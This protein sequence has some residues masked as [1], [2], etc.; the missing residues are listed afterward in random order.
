MISAIFDEIALKVN[1]IMAAKPGQAAPDVIAYLESKTEECA[2]T[3]RDSLAKS[4]FRPDTKQA[5]ENFINSTMAETDAVVK[6][7]NS[8]DAFNKN[9]T[10]TANDVARQVTHF[11][12]TYSRQA[13]RKLIQ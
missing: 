10:L 6:S 5:R 3:Q 9:N 2:K 12:L 4:D 11:V 1:E 13:V 8:T 7:Q